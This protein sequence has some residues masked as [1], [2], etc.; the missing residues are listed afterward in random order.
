MDEALIEN[1]I[2]AAGEDMFEEVNEDNE[3]LFDQ[4]FDY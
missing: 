2:L 4:D 3:P 1:D